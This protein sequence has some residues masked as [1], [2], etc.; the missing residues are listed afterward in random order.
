LTIDF[1]ILVD[2][3]T[4]LYILKYGFCLIEVLK[5]ARKKGVR[6]RTRTKYIRSRSKNA[7]GSFKPAISG[8]IAGAGSNF[9]SGYVGAYAPVVSNLAVGLFMKDKTAMFLAGYNGA[10]ML[11]NGNNGTTGGGVR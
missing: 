8:A 11:M 10:A 4:K 2:T 3:Y 7:F 9:L 1:K 6:Y 5:I